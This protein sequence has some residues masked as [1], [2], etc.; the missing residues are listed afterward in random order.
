MRGLDMAGP[1]TEFFNQLPLVEVHSKIDSR[2]I[3]NKTTGEI[4][5]IKT[6]AGYLS[7]VDENGVSLKSP[8]RIDLGRDGTPYAPGLYVLHGISLNANQWKD[9]ELKRYG[10]KLLSVPPIVNT[11]LEQE[12]K[13]A[14]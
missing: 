3:T 2:S 8:V 9:L 5:Q 14:A 11:M 6:Q 10:V 12:A 1:F 4:S 7:Q 13:R